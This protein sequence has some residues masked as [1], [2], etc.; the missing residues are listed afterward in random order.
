ME[1]AERPAAN[2]MSMQSAPVWVPN[3][4]PQEILA[5][6]ENGDVGGCCVS[7]NIIGTLYLDGTE[8]TNV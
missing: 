3:E 7:A 4:T 2:A 6:Q 8:P 5:P 1:T